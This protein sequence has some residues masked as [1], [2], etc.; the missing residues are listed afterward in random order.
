[1]PTVYVYVLLN[2][3]ISDFGPMRLGKNT[4]HWP[5]ARDSTAPLKGDTPSFYLPTTPREI[6]ALGWKRPDIILVTGDA[7]IDSPYIGVAVIGRVLLNAGFKTAVIAQPDIASGADITRLGEPSLFWGITGGAVDSLVANY[8]AVK[9][10]RNTDDLTPG[11]INNRRPDRAVMR[12]ANLIR[13]YFKNTVPLV[14]GGIESSLRRIAHYDFWSDKI[15][16]SILFDAKADLLIYGMGEKT[17][18]QLSRALKDGKPAENIPGLCYISKEKPTDY[19]ELP[20]FQDINRRA[21]KFIEMYE[22]FYQNNDPLTAKG[23]YQQHDL[24]YLVQNP[25]PPLLS[26]AELDA[27]HNLGYNRDLHPYYRSLGPV[28]ALDTIRFSIPTHRGCYGECNF[29]AIAVHQGRTVSWRS[30]AAILK[31]ARAIARMPEFAGVITDA[32]GPTANMYGFECSLKLIKGACSGKRCLYPEVCSG[33]HPDHGRLL[34]LLKKLAAIEGVKHV[35]TASGIRYDL[36]FSDQNAG[37]RYLRQVVSR[38]VSGQ[39]KIAPEHTEDDILGL[40]GKPGVNLLLDFKKAF[41]EFS[42]K[43]GKHQFLTYYLIAAH[44]GCRTSH[45]SALKRFTRE[46]LKINPQ[47]VQIFTPTPST[48]SSVMYYTGIN[49]FTGKKLFVEKTVRGREN[50]KKLVTDKDTGFLKAGKQNFKADSLKKAIGLKKTA[51]PKK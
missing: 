51:C 15:R 23:L 43:S 44:P 30:E 36:I 42:L 21:E 27:V 7:Y 16:K 29:C 34:S 50:Q 3:C 32:G 39:L 6:K 31:E 8:T 14:L 47:Q 37:M 9:K 13:Q 4:G 2:F 20:S 5:M 40:M 38:H 25:P 22:I 18:V 17:V 10:R 28:K 24:R 33:L 35:F 45:M 48:W 46:N 11:G 49:P 1:M 26:Q 41:D 19:I 12:Y